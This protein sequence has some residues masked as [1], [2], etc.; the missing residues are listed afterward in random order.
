VSN[1]TAAGANDSVEN[2]TADDFEDL[3]TERTVAAAL[4]VGDPKLRWLLL[5]A[6]EKVSITVVE[7]NCEADRFDE[8]AATLD[9]LRPEILFLGLAG[10]SVDPGAVIARIATLDPAPRV[11]AVNDTAAPE[12]I[13]KAM[14][15]GA[16]DVVYPPFSSTAFLDSLRRVIA[17]CGQMGAEQRSTGSVIGFVSAKGGCGAT[18]LACHSS[19]HLRRM[20]GKEVLLADLD[21]ASG[22]SS[23]I[24]Q[25]VAR[26]SLHDALQ[27]LHRM[28]LKLWKGLVTT[29]PS[30]VDVIPAPP[31]L[32]APSAPISRKLPPLLRF[33]RMQYDFTII[34]FGHGIT[35]PLLDVLDSIDALVLV[36]TNEVLA[37]KQAKQIIQTL[38]TRNLGA[39]RV[40]LVINRMPKRSQIQ[41]PELEKVMGYSIYAEIPNDYERLSEA[42]SEPRL[43]DPGST[44]GAEIGKFAAKMAGI[45]SNEKKK[46]RRFFR[47]RSRK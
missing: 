24:M 29:A 6:L 27:N 18:T 8:M 3:G 45:T 37:L 44:L 31:D 32:P 36:A 5:E 13:V 19:A 39:N 17:D 38:A 47:L 20:T 23:I 43:L 33:W 41:L 4:A 42:Y 46:S 1:N 22:I 25:T 16:A 21:M 28:D 34:D 10:L 7:E 11:V 9:R 26:Y 15:A 12:A 30:G 40:R 35:Q 14:R 2:K